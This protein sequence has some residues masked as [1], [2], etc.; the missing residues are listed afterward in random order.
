MKFLPHHTVRVH[1]IGEVF[2]N[3][4]HDF[5]NR[6]EGL[7]SSGGP[8]SLRPILVYPVL[9]L[10]SLSFDGYS[11]RKCRPIFKSCLILADLFRLWLVFRSVRWPLPR[12]ALG[13]FIR[14][15]PKIHLA[16]CCMR[17]NRDPVRCTVSS[18]PC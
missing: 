10:Q 9:K 2:A 3:F 15:A 5:V 14:T 7:C 11:T 12:V 4:Y 13:H 1:H 18:S 6:R 16:R 8:Y 17:R